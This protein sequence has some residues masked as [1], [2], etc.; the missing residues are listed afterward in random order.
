MNDE[1]PKKK[2]TWLWVVLGVFLFFGM[3]AVGGII[4]AVSFFRQSLDVTQNVRETEASPE[5]D[6]IY[7]KFPGQKPMIQLVD[8]DPK[9]VVESGTKPGS[10]LTTLHVLAYSRDEENLAR[11]ALP[12]W[13][14]RMKSGPIR[15]SAYSQGWDDRG[16]FFR[17]EDIEKHGPGIIVDVD[18]RRD[19]RMLI[20]AE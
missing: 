7:A 18:R 2:K 3:I 6:A 12:F 14:I 10:P 19:G 5:F 13:L 11:L 16:V 20:W 15:M 1:A 8:G 4:V 17:V 9:V